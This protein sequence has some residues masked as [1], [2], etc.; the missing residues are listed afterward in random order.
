MVV[1][2][3]NVQG[4]KYTNPLKPPQNHSVD[5]HPPSLLPGTSHKCRPILFQEKDWLK[6]PSSKQLI[7]CGETPRY[8]VIPQ[9]FKLK[10]QKKTIVEATPKQPQNCRAWEWFLGS[11]AISQATLVFQN[12]P[13]IPCEKM[14]WNPLKAEPPTHKFFGRLGKHGWKREVT[15]RVSLCL[16]V[17]PTYIFSGEDAV[18]FREDL[19]PR[20]L[21]MSPE[22]RYLKKVEI[23]L[24][25]ITWFFPAVSFQV[26]NI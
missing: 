10:I 7:F 2:F 22:N 12:P 16:W 20:K 23:L 24:E 5:T 3:P 9:I 15:R 6:Q 19:H 4:Q 17:E 26:I 8:L 21:R 18:S 14:V 25:T 11:Q 13:V 1:S